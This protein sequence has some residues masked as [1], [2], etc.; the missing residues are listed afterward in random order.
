[1]EG[2][3]R[4]RSGYRIAYADRLR[5]AAI[6]RCA[7]RIG[8]K[9]IPTSAQASDPPSSRTTAAAVGLLPTPSAVSGASFA[10]DACTHSDRHRRARAAC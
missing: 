9:P 6:A 10:K 8:L 5:I 2:S 1:M 4:E 3:I 7:D